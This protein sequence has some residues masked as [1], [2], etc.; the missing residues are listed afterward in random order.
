[1]DIFQRAGVYVYWV[2]NNTG[3][4]GVCNRI[5]NELITHRNLPE[6]CQGGECMDDI[7]LTDFDKLID[8]AQE[9]D[10]VLVLIED[11]KSVV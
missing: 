9:K 3:C 1:M 6:Y 10:A 7:L 2:D 11:R 4:K 8:S 5:P